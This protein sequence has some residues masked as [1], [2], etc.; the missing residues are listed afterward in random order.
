MDQLHPKRRAHERTRP[1]DEHLAWSPGYGFPL[2][3]ADV[4]DKSESG[5]GLAVRA[6]HA[7]SHGGAIRLI[8]GHSREPRRARIV[9][10][11]EAEDGLVRLGCRWISA[12]DRPHHPRSVRRLRPQVDADRPSF[13][14][15][16]SS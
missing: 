10:V 16:S 15:V 7:P 3:R 5:I 4:V 11:S 2:L 6:D 13:A 9:R 12:G 14:A 8:N 1:R